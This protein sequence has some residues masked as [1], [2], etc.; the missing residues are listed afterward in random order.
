MSANII[1]APLDALGQVLASLCIG[2][3][4]TIALAARA[5][6]FVPAM[7]RRVPEILT[8]MHAYGVKTLPVTGVVGLFFG[9]ILALQ[10]GIE[11]DKFGQ[12]DAVGLVVTAAMCREMGPFIAALVLSSTVGSG[13][14]AEIGTMKVSDEVDALEIMAIDPVKYLV[15]PRLVALTLICP[16]LT[17]LV[18][19]LGVLGGQIV[20][21]A[22]LGVSREVF[23]DQAIQV[24][25][26]SRTI[27]DWPKDVYTG[28]VKAVVFGVTIAA[29]GL[30]AGMRA[31]GGALGVGRA[32]RGAVVNCLL[33]IIIFS[34]F[35]TWLFYR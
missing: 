27:F 25:R 11:L 33:L 31:H 4:Y 19:F 2:A 1:T 30:S 8:L 20:S 29:V 22:Q 5:V 16:I 35:M 32:V 17:I 12:V 10:T 14:A 24:L 9:A 34:Y 3:G 18:D 15:T 26:Y 13:M 7:Y 28:L 23:V 21:Q 6:M